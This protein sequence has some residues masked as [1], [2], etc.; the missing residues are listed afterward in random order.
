VHIG[1]AL[2]AHVIDPG[3]LAPEELLVAAWAAAVDEHAQRPIQHRGGVLG[4]SHP[5]EQQ[6]ARTEQGPN[7]D[8]HVRAFF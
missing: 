3:D 4:A 2:V 7:E 5:W 1:V 8:G 6:H